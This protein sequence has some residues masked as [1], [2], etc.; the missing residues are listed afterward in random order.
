VPSSTG[1]ARAT[2]LV[3]ASMKGRL[4]GTSL[5]V[6]CRSQ[7]HRLHGDR[8]VDERSTRSNAAFRAAAEGPL[9]GVLVYTD[10]TSSLRTSSA[11]RRRAPSDS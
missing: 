9:K 10:D 3:L 2:S 8:L 4:D 1:A 6:R 7:H 5:R 11:P